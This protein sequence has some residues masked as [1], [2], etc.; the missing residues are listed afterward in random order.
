MTG[1]DS[2]IA[3]GAGIIFAHVI[4]SIR[5]TTQFTSV[6]SA[7]KNTKSPTTLIITQR[8][9]HYPLIDWNTHELE[10]IRRRRIHI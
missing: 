6:V 8:R 2:S 7:K 9:L 5:S 10:L 3:I 4:S 1:C